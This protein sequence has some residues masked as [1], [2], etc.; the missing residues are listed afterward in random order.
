MA[1]GPEAP[2]AK[3]AKLEPVALPAN[4]IVQFQ[5]DAG[6][7]VGKGC[8]TSSFARHPALCSPR[9]IVMGCHDLKGLQL[10]L[11][12]RNDQYKCCDLGGVCK[13]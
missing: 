12:I 8:S 4:V 5:N 13:D 9:Y 10:L 3:Q 6:E 1:R 2:P 7:L 11:M